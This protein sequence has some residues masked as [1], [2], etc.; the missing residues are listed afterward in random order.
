MSSAAISRL[1]QIVPMPRNQSPRPF[2]ALPGKWLVG[3]QR[4]ANRRYGFVLFGSSGALDDFMSGYNRPYVLKT[5]LQT[6]TVSLSSE[7]DSKANTI[8]VGDLEAWRE[9]ISRV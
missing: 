2:L 5:E 4:Q 1:P 3:I 9:I 6:K 8:F 7:R